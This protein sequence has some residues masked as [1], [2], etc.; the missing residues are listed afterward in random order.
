MTAPGGG[1]C[2]GPRSS[3]RRRERRNGDGTKD[4]PDK[5]QI[6]KAAQSFWHD[7]LSEDVKS[8]LNAKNIRTNTGT[9]DV[10]FG[11]ARIKLGTRGYSSMAH[12]DKILA[13]G[14]FECTDDGVATF[15]WKHA[16]KFDEEW[17]PLEDTTALVSQLSLS[18]GESFTFLCIRI[19][20]RFYYFGLG[21]QTTFESKQV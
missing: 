16:L 3:H 7:S 8:V 10:A 13:E 19:T 15:T 14:T 17:K 12:G 11:P 2:T 4:K 20:L 9:I 6:E 18:A 1:P 5:S 21:C